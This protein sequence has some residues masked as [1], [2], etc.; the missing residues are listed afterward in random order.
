M[1]TCARHCL[2]R[3]SVLSTWP[4]QFIKQKFHSS[5]YRTLKRKDSDSQTAHRGREQKLKSTL[6]YLTAAGVL[7]VGF[8]YAAVPLY[9]MFCQAYSYG[10]TVSKH[11]DTGK[12]E[13]MEK[14]SDRVVKVKFNADLGAS[15]R[16]NFKP[17]QN[18]IKVPVGE[19]ALAFYTARNPTDTPVIGISTYNV[20]PYEAGQYFNKIQCFCFEEQQLNPHEEVDMP[21][22]FY[23]DPEFSEDPKMELVDTI[24][25]SYTFFEAKEGLTL[26]VP[27]FV[28]K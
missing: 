5:S 8:S 1:F 22:F 27:S 26:P 7:T 10:G 13:N 2:K 4:T 15:M 23:I 28:R 11:D 14:K 25:L 24:V 19:T 16:W 18:E 9:R 12:I 21:V 6:Y 20:V 3:T 17:Q